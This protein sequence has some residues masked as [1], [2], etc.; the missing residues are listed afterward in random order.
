[1]DKNRLVRMMAIVG[2]LVMVAT[3]VWADTGAING[4]CGQGGTSA[5][6][7]RGKHDYVVKLENTGTCPINAD[8]SYDHQLAM[9]QLAP[10]AGTAF[11]EYEKLAS[12]TFGCGEQ[13]GSCQLTVSI[14]PIK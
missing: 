6:S 1:M 5:F 4:Q 9:I 14:Q 3:P 8:V 12:I 7:G 2:V 11:T 10:A 13:G